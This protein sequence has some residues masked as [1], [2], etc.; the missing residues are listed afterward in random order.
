M[1]VE[2]SRNNFFPYPW[3]SA[4]LIVFISLF[5]F[6]IPVHAVPNGTE[7]ILTTGTDP[8]I[9][10]HPS[11][12]GD[13]VVW[14]NRA[15]PLYI[16]LDLV[17]LATGQLRELPITDGSIYTPDQPFLTPDTIVWHEYDGT[18]GAR[19][20]RYDLTSSAIVNYYDGNYDP[21]IPEYTFPR[22]SGNTIVWQNYN[23]THSDWDIAVVRDS[24][25]L[26]PELILCSGNDEK[27][28]SVYGNFIVY[29]NWTDATHAHIWRFNLTDNT[30]VQV[31]AS[32][33]QEIFPQVY[34]SRIVWQARNISD[35]R[36]HVNV[37]E[38]DIL[39][40]LTPP[41]IDQEHPAIDGN[42]IAVEDYRRDAVKPD[43]Y[44][45]E[46]S[47]GWTE[48]WLSPNNYHASQITP[49]V[50][51]NRIVWED[52]RSGNACGG[53][54][55]DIYLFTRGTADTCPVADFTPSVNSGPDP[56]TV[57]FTD[58]S[59]GSPIL[60]RI[61]NY[62]DGM[63]SYPLDP[64]GHSFTPAGIYH[65]RLTVGNMK[66]RNISPNLTKYDIYID[67]PPSADF[68][69]TPL[70]G[71]AP[72][73][74]QFTDTS[75][76]DPSSWTWDFGDGGISHLRNPV[77]SYL[78]AGHTYPVSLTVNNSLAMMAA[79]TQTKNDYVRTFNGATGTA[80]IPINGIIVIPRFGGLFLVYNATMLPDMARP[81]PTILSS[82]N[83][84]DS[85][86]QN[87]TF[88]SRDAAGFADTYGNN[89][90]MGNLSQ[91]VFQT[92]DVIS[93]VSSPDIGTGWGVN[94]RFSSPAYF[95]PAALNT[96]IWESA[97]SADRALFRAVVIGSNFVENPDGVAYT[98]QI[99]KNGIVGESDEAVINMSVDRSWINGNESRIYVIGYGINNDGNTVGSAI[100]AHFLFTAGSLDYFEAD[101]PKYFSKFGISPLSGSG[102]PLQLITLTIQSH[103][104]PPSPPSNPD[105]ES[106]SGMQ[107]AATGTRTATPTPTPTMTPNATLT[108][109]QADPGTSAKIYTN[110]NGVV[111]Q[112]T[113]LVSTDGLATLILGTGVMAKDAA[114]KPLT[115]IT[116]KALPQG[117]LPPVPSGSSLTF[118]GRA[119]E[120]GPEGATFSPPLIVSFAAPP[121]QPGNGYTV[122]SFDLKS[123]SWQDL[124]TTFDAASGTI[125]ADAGHLCCIALFTRAQS[126]A[127]TPPVHASSPAAPVPAATPDRT[128]PPSTAVSIFMSMV[129]WVA[130]LIVNNIIPLIAAIAIGISGYLV[131][132]GMH[133]GSGQ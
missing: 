25:I 113:R 10:N 14:V 75:G 78:T 91:V 1:P 34:G 59:A 114:G 111:T 81:G 47:A 123:G 12:N 23:V 90:Y 11:I 9:K 38:N 7:T 98:A 35:T 86:W 39:T 57:V 18:G 27:H 4:C 121:G 19:V 82:F 21:S 124:P 127:P 58:R 30:S 104:N 119:Y 53:C 101:V 50:S 97:T 6:L 106:D 40:T 64:S 22:I 74:V 112:A 72:L 48:I 69:A 87:V 52:S 45:Y 49:S 61:W 68:T 32:S 66:C 103:V 100:P 15:D 83:P 73:N 36:N 96:A 126:A 5:L 77:H 51:G 17:N 41:G 95:S 16:V 3:K 28:P 63:T 117:S 56:T 130:G 80:S 8:F 31:S 122:R 131:M 128:Q 44:V 108:A 54:D 118:A 107:G 129:A 70:E 76:G 24:T 85:G 94:Y 132:Q 43:I 88:I 92:E 37:L 133:P 65:A 33:D 116:L 20:V 60:Y 46:Y 125:T 120:I 105:S 42:R 26:S 62:S 99:D 67:T 55:S 115:Q 102:N 110:G 109:G 93:S 71:F 29:E 2:K 79:N 13:N 84:G 89:T